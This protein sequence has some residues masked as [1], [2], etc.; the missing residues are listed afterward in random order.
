MA[1]ANKMGSMV[2]ST[3]NKSEMSVGYAT[4]YGDMCGGYSVLK[5]VY[6]MTVFELS[7]WRNENKPKGALG[8]FGPVMPDRVITKPPSAEL[9]PDQ[10]DQDTLPPY[11]DLDKILNGLID[12]ESTVEE[13][14]GMAEIVLKQIVLNDSQ[15]RRCTI[16][17]DTKSLAAKVYDAQPVIYERHRHRYEVNAAFVPGLESNG[18]CIIDSIK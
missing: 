14:V 9:K 4:L 5:D 7:K 8:P 1:L 2:L 18:F 11:E 16:I 17:K 6:K 13:I 12:N 10:V 3:G 15:I